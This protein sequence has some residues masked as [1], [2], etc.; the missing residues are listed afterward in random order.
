MRCFSA[1]EISAGVLMV[2]HQ[3]KRHPSNVSII[4]YIFILI[5]ISA[6]YLAA[7]A[8]VAFHTWHFQYILNMRQDIR[9]PVPTCSLPKIKERP[10]R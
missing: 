8:A 6:L 4:K 5:L 3:T 7:R 1:T 10:S 2:L 9:E